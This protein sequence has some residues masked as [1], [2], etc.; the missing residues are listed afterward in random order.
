VPHATASR[1]GVLGL[2]PIL[3]VARERGLDPD[4]LL[5][6]AGIASAVLD[7]PHA[8][9]PVEQVHALVQALLDRTGEPTLGLEAAR[10]LHPETFG[11]LGAV[12]VVTP[13]MREVIELFIQYSHLIF[14]FFLH[15]FDEAPG[16]TRLL[17]VADGE[18]GPLHRFYLDRELAFVAESARTFWPDSYREIL[19]GF[20]FD[21]PEPAEAARYRS[22]FPCEVRFGAAQAAVLGDFSRDRP[23]VAVNPLGYDVLKE[24]LSTFAGAPSDSG[25]IVDRVRHEIAVAVTTRQ[26]LPAADQIA[27]SLGLSERVLRRRLATVGTSFRA[28]T[29]EV[30]APLAKRY[31]RESGLSVADVAERVGYSEAA[32]FVRAFRRWTGTTPEVFRTGKS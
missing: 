14:S 2:P 15:Q 30:V 16:A 10:H 28:L 32:S 11:L 31:L 12:A 4:A 6:K 20:D 8:D 23:R 21:Y 22:F 3:A 24:H 29:D 9:V 1:Y 7:D 26:A 17:F 27:A 13:T 5:R 25:D 19:R 18:L